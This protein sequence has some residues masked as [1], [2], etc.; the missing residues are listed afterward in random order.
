MDGHTYSAVLVV[1]FFF[2]KV[3][4]NRLLTPKTV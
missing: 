4:A 2:L 3:T 1:Y